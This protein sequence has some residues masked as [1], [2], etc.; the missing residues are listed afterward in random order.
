MQSNQRT[1]LLS[2]FILFSVVWAGCA[3]ETASDRQEPELAEQGTRQPAAQTTADTGA[4][5]HPPASLS[6]E[7]Q[8]HTMRD[9]VLGYA[10]VSQALAQGEG[11][12]AAAAARA[13][14]QLAD[15]IPAFMLHVEGV[16]RGDLR[17][18]ARQFKGEMLRVAELA[19]RDSIEA[20]QALHRRVT[21]TCQACHKKYMAAPVRPADMEP[22]EPEGEAAEHEEAGHERSGH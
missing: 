6:M 22:M 3:R 18:Y 2:L 1:L 21:Q 4:A 11:P 20:A 5:L 16:G 7:A 13:V 19:E 17:R 9:I 12:T 8:H 10:E 14:G 15:R